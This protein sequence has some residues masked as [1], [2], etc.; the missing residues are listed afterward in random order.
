MMLTP[1]CLLILYVE[2]LREELT[3]KVADLSLENEK[4]KM[5]ST[6]FSSRDSIR[7]CL[8]VCRDLI[9]LSLFM[10]LRMCFVLMIR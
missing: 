5:V 1:I 4:M 9:C 8:S 3:R 6:T 2:A 10:T 7:S